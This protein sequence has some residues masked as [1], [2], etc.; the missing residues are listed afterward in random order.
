VGGIR[1]IHE[2][3]FAYVFVMASELV[4]GVMVGAKM[5]AVGETVRE[6]TVDVANDRLGRAA[7][8]AALEV[9]VALGE[10]AAGIRLAKAEV[11]RM[12]ASAAGWAARGAWAAAHPSVSR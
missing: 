11:R 8:D 9:E 4:P 3:V 7:G 2:H 1:L 12:R 10:L 5:C 6:T